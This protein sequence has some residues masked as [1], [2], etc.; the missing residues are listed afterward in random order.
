MWGYKL[1]CKTWAQGWTSRETATLYALPPCLADAVGSCLFQD[2]MKC[3]CCRSLSPVSL[4]VITRYQKYSVFPSPQYS[5]ASISTGPQQQH[6]TFYEIRTYNIQPH[7]N[8]AFLKLTSEKIHLRTAHSELV[9]YWSVEYGGLNQVF[10]IWKYGKGNFS[11]CVFSSAI[12]STSYQS[13][14]HLLCTAENLFWLLHG[15][16]KFLCRFYGL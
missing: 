2:W 13:W 11:M 5:S 12:L 7:L 15:R 1:F 8:T 3:K 6:G 10:H 16:L 4:V 14:I 9:G